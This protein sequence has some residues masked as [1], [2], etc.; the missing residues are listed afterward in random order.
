VALSPGR[1]ELGVGQQCS[2]FNVEDGFTSSGIWRCVFGRV[3]P[4]VSE[5]RDALIL[6]DEAVEEESQTSYFIQYC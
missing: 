2:H 3:I 6:K 1:E 4:D 5:K